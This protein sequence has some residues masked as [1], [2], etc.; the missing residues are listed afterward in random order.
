VLTQPRWR[1]PNSISSSSSA[2]QA[3]TPFS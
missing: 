1:R 3:V 2:S